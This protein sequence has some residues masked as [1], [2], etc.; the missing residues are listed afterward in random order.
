MAPAVFDLAAKVA[1]TS[2]AA[3]MK[4]LEKSPELIDWVGWEGFG[5]I[6]AFIE[7]TA[8]EDEQKALSFLASESPTWTDFLENIPKGLEL[9]TIQPILSHYLKALLGRRVEIAEAAEGLYGRKKN[10]P[11]RTDPR[12]SKSGR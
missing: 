9:K 12:F 11:P 4:L 8:G 3:A 2:P 7:N 1:R 6:A 5:K 10:L